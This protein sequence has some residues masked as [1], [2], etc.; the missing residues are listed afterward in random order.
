MVNIAE[1]AGVSR[2]ALYQH[3]PGKAELLVALNDFVI[4]EWRAWTQESVV[5]AQTACH[6]IERWLRDGLADS[7]RVTVVR[8]VT[9]EGTQ[10]ELLT[11][12]GA[13]RDAMRETRRVLAKMLERGVESGELRADLD[14][15]ATAHGLQAILLGLLRNHAS[16]R[17]IVAIERRRDLDALVELVLAGLRRT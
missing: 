2:A 3:F 1:A 15:G 12:R 9:A 8:V 5:L 16:E 7:W 14:V 4:A 6:A 11:D 17:P 10:G 13:T